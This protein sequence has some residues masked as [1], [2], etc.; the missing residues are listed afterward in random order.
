MRKLILV[1]GRT[2]L[3]IN[4]LAVSFLTMLSI[5]KLGEP[6]KIPVSLSG[7][8]AELRSDHFHGGVDIKGVVGTPVY[9]VEDGFLY[10]LES[11]GTGYGNVIYIKHKNGYMS[12]YGHLSAFINQFEMHYNKEATKYK[13]SNFSVYFRQDEILVKKG[14]KIGEI[15][16]SGFSF[17]PHLHYEVRDIKKNKQIN[18]LLFS[19]NIYD[20]SPPKWVSLKLVNVDKNRISRSESFIK[21]HENAY[22]SV[23]TLNLIVGKSAL[24]AQV[25]DG[26]EGNKNR[27]GVYQLKM[28]VDGKLYFHFLADKIA[29]P[30]SEYANA[31]IDF[32]ENKLSKNIFYR[33]YRLPGNNLTSYKHLQNDGYFDVKYGKITNIEVEALDYSGNYS[34]KRIAIRGVNGCLPSLPCHNQYVYRKIDNLF[35]N[36][37]IEVNIPKGAVYQNIPFKYREI[38]EMRGETFSRIHSVHNEDEPLHKNIFLSIRS[39][40]MPDYLRKK[41]F[42]SGCNQQG[43]YINYGGKWRKDFMEGQVDQFGEFSIMIDTIPPVIKDLSLAGKNKKDFFLKF[44]LSDNVDLPESIDYPFFKVTLNGQWIRMRSDSKSGIISGHLPVDLKKGKYE[45]KVTSWDKMKNISH[46]TKSF[47]VRR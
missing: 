43:K 41:S 26:M 35:K 2:I 20:C 19:V 46:L 7:T 24:A 30:E 37:F 6:V 23:D 9:A 3:K 38:K 25:Y 10:K 5:T 4:L 34:R 47:T 36:Y 8:F 33:C 39:G 44:Q 28:Y 14:D 45:I 21:L 32:K 27:N 11:K 31:F 16:N 40:I 29:V 15:G 22:F 18:P 12:V 42:I 1:P 17:G 13:K